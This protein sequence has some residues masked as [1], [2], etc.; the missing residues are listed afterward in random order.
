M[1]EE[2]PNE[3][4]A[5]AKEGQREGKTAMGLPESWRV[6]LPIFEGPLDLLLH[7]IRINEVD[8]Y[9]IPVLL[10]CDQFHEYL[11]LMEELDLD[12][13]GEF[14]YEAALL[15]QLKSRMLLPKPKVEEGEEE[16]DPREI[17]VQRLLEYQRMKEAA[18]ELGEVDRLRMGMWTRDAGPPDLGTA[19]DEEVDLGDL[20]LFDLLAAFKRVL[21]R[22]DREHPPPIHLRGESY[23]VRDQFQRL[24]RILDAGRPYDLLDDLRLLTCRAEAVAAFLA[25]LELAKLNLIRLHQTEK[26]EILLHRTTR[27]IQDHEL[28]LIQG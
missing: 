28:E 9:D 26:G 18:Q 25:I 20:S 19:T 7:L 12:I 11:S 10:I 6:H 24:L 1:S 8:V 23:S 27:D 15:I 16:E 21:V 17:L 14:I 5:S 3:S 13:A 4:E 2:F 22:Y